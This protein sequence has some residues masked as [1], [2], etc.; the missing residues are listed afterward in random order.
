[1]RSNDTIIAKAFADHSASLALHICARIQ[2][3]EEAKDMVQ[4]VFLRLLGMEL[5]TEETVKS[6]CYTIANNLVID[7]IRRHYKREEVYSY[8]Y[9]QVEQSHSL[10]PEQI[11]VFH[12]IASQEQC[13]ISQLSPISRKVYEMTRMD[14]RTITE[15]AEELD[16]PR[17]TVESHQFRARKAVREHMRRVI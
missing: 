6:L 12:E 14:G 5:I 3:M 10:T 11:A 7:Y 4:E 9:D 1:M 16:M 17:R 15:I 13:A 8:W 2:D